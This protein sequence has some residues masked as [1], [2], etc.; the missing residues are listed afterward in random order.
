MIIFFILKQINYCDINCC[1]DIDCSNDE[2]KTFICL[3]NHWSL[4]DYD[5]FSGGLQ[6]CKIHNSLLC[7]VHDDTTIEQVYEKKKMC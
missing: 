4:Y 7:V 1:C 5:H 2:R 3:E 6:S